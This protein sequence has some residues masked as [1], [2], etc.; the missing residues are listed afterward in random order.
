[1]K[2]QTFLLIVVCVLL[3]WP[4]TPPLPSVDAFELASNEGMVAIAANLSES[5][6]ASPDTIPDKVKKC[7][8]GGSGYVM[9]PDGVTRVRC[10]CGPDCKC[11]KADKVEVCLKCGRSDCASLTQSFSSEYRRT[12]FNPNLTQQILFFTS[13][14]CSPCNSWKLNEKPKMEAAKFVVS[15]DTMA[16]VLI[17]DSDS[18]PELVNAFRVQAVPSFIKVEKGKEVFR[19]TGYTPAEN[20]MKL[21]K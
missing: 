19:Y 3:L 2:T 9:T 13:A 16:H 8:C 14:G 20:L 11:E 4:T 17:I 6:E 5:R 21:W 18:N 10:E 1:M 15:D 12:S 7:K